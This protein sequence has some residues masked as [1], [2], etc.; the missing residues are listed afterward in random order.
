LDDGYVAITEWCVSLTGGVW[1]GPSG[2]PSFTK[3]PSSDWLGPPGVPPFAKPPSS[4]WLGPPGVPPF[5]KP[6]SSGSIYWVKSK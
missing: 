3:P 4:D 6:P 5:A 2:V 1:L